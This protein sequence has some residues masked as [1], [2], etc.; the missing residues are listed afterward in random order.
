[1][2]GKVNY[3]RGRWSA[4]SQQ[5]GAAVDATGCVLGR[6]VM[7]GEATEELQVWGARGSQLGGRAKIQTGARAAPRT[8]RV[9]MLGSGSSPGLCVFRAPLVALTHT[10]S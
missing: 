8:C 6:S 1:M 4:P 9:Q 10:P 3:M 7:S 5:E 2:G